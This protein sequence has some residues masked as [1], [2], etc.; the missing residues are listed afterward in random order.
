MFVTMRSRLWKRSSEQV[1]SA[2]SDETTGAEL[3]TQGQFRD[4]LPY[5]R[6]T[7]G[8]TAVDV[9]REGPPPSPESEDQAHPWP[10][11][12]EEGSE[13]SIRTRSEPEPG[14]STSSVDHRDWDSQEGD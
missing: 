4:L 2:A 12:P 5:L 11:I 1:R 14:A 9:E 10:S 6:G 3:V 8:T 13:Q 7:R